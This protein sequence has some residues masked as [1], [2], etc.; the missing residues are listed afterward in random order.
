MHWAS[1]CV[2]GPPPGLQGAM[3]QPSR[4]AGQPCAAW[5]E[6][7]PIEQAGFKRHGFG[8]T[9]FGG[10]KVHSLCATHA[11][12]IGLK[13]PFGCVLLAGCRHRNHRRRACANARPRRCS[14]QAG[15]QGQQPARVAGG[16]AAAGA[17]AAPPLRAGF[18][19][20]DQ[21]RRLLRPHHPTA[22]GRWVPPLPPSL[23]LRMPPLPC[24]PAA[25]AL[26]TL[27]G[28][29]PCWSLTRHAGA[30]AAAACS[31]VQPVVCAGIPPLCAGGQG[32][33]R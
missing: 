31:G 7:M 14:P 21:Q 5:L 3:H 1:A 32:L 16:R 12:C 8:A 17:A 19:A 33:L 28:G 2:H 27:P 25:P 18:Q 30:A 4:L 9:L 15:R 13:T 26:P 22:G 6:C 11:C 29:A 24:G 10:P 23:L 20:A